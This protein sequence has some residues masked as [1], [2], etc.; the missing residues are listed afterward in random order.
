MVRRRDQID[1]ILAS[2]LPR[3]ESRNILQVRQSTF[4]IAIALL[5]GAVVG[6]GGSTV[7]YR[8][9]WFRPP[10]ERPFDR[11]GRALALSDVQRG[12]VRAVLEE[13]KRELSQARVAFETTQ[14]RLMLTAYLRTRAL[15]DPDQQ[16]KFDRKFVSDELLREAREK[17][18]RQEATASS[19][20]IVHA[21]PT[22]SR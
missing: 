14:R 2:R 17:S 1:P 11:M 21:A 19:A 10:G 5:A 22:A 20:P 6:F 13:T 16:I 9:R 7:S 15:L 4:L 12:Q 8:H 3:E 18:A